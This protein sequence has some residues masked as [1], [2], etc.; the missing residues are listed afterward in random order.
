MISLTTLHRG[1]ATKAGHYYSD[2]KDDYYSRDGGSAQW[3]GEGVQALGLTGEVGQDQFVAAL[4]GDFGPEVNLSRSVRK[5]AKARAAMDV[6]FSAPKSI[7]IQALV[8]KD[9]TVLAAHDHAV[10]KALEFLER[11]LVRARQKQNGETV[12]E[13]SG[14]AVIAKFRHETARPSDFDEAD[15]QLHTHTLVMNVTRRAD[16]A[17]VS[18]SNEQIYRAKMLMDVIYKNEMAAYLEYAGYALRYE[19]DNFE[20]AHISREQIERFSKRG[21][22][23]QAELAKMGKTRKS[24]SRALKQAI[25]LATRNDK[26]PEITRGMLQTGWEKEAQ[27]LGIDFSTARPG[28]GLEPAGPGFG[29]EEPTD[30]RPLLPKDPGQAAPP[31]EPRMPGPGR[32]AP[33]P[34]IDHGA[35]ILRDG[36]ARECVVWAIRHMAEREA[37]MS[38]RKLTEMAMMHA[39]GTGATYW[40]IKEAIRNEVKSGHLV[41]GAPVYTSEYVDSGNLALSREVWVQR[42]IGG[43]AS[44]EQAR[45][46]VR[47]AI[48]QGGLVLAD[49]HYTTQVTREREKRILQIERDGR[50]VMEPVLTPVQAGNALTGKSLKPGQLAAAELI[51][52]TSHRVVGVQGLAGT[53]KSHMLKEVKTAME[54]AGYTVKSVAPYGSQVKAL[55]ILGVQAI[56]VAAMLEA[57]IR[58]LE[59]DSKTVL[60]VDEAGVVPARQME[61]ILQRVEKAGARVVLMGDKDQTK[62]IEAGRPMHQLQDAGMQTALMADIVRQRNPLLRRAVEL[63]AV[64]QASAALHVIQTKLDSVQE[65]KENILRYD[66]IS[67]SYAGLAQD[68]RR[69]TLIVTGTNESRRALN[70]LVHEKLGLAG[71]GMHFGLLTRVDTTQA[72]RRSAKYYEVGQIIQPERNYKNRLEQDNQYV[73][74][75]VDSARNRIGVRHLVSGELLEFNPARTSKLSIYEWLDA[76]LSPGDS[77]RVT[78]NDAKLDLV[79]GERYDVLAVSAG[80]VTLGQVGD[81]GQIIR[82][83]QLDGNQTDKPLHMDL[84]YASTVHSAQG[85]SETGV[86][87]NVETFSRTTKLDVFY[88]GISRAKDRIQVFTDDMTKLPFAVA[89]REDKTAALDIG[90]AAKSSQAEISKGSRTAPHSELS[91]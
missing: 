42:M 11:E 8:G 60:V 32:P 51:L 1:N 53:G 21:M 6:T 89:R 58:H 71:Q 91:I 25:T 43:G 23:V 88:V 76:E 72:Q 73:V 52:S 26:R 17:W 50:G 35:Q 46:H 40:E 38:D 20:L 87:A 33:K 55:R 29:P 9:A 31:V 78:H 74:T 27:D 18:V 84:A 49:V 37:V 63:A 15:P 44:P 47:R 36:I 39:V 41:Q 48:A 34:G 90:I 75:T 24:A 2:Q 28:K 62:A 66:A 56:T 10:T 65:I 85:L 5:D 67:S 82:K 81:N 45:Q 86:M 3:Q 69:Q 83:I 30:N 79:N 77:V 14:N 12:S 16:G 13:K 22:T 19:K 61:K 59:L 64:G 4:R 70:R 80:T 7:S 57:Q 54:S 68:E